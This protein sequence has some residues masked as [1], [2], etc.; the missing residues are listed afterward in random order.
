MSFSLNDQQHAAVTHMGTPLLV[1][2]GA[3][4]GKTRVITQKIA[5]LIEKQGIS[6][7][8]IFAVT[9]TNK[10]AREMKERVSAQLVGGSAKGLTIS[11]FHSLGLHI[12][13]QEAAALGLKKGFSIFDPNDAQLVVKDLMRADFSKEDELIVQVRN[14]ISSW[15]NDLISVSEAQLLGMTEPVQVAASRV[16][17]AYE[18]HLKACNAVDLDDLISRPIHLF[19]TQP[20]ILDQWRSKVGFFLVDEYQDTNAAQ[21]KMVKLLVGNGT[22]L[23]AVGDDDQSIYGWRGAKPDNLV[24]LGQDFPTLKLV[25][26]EQNYRSMGRILHTANHLIQNNQRPFEKSLWSEL[27][28]GDPI[29]VIGAKTD[30][31]EAEKVVSALMH[32][33]FQKGSEYSDYAILYRGNHQARIFETKLREMHIPYYLSGGMSYFDRA[34]IKDVMG[35]L[36]LLTNPLDDNA[37]IRAINTPRR[38]IGPG[39]IEKLGEAS[40]LANCSLY[41]AITA[42]ELHQTLTPKKQGPLKAFGNWLENIKEIERSVSPLKLVNDL[43]EEIQYEQYLQDNSPT[44]EQGERRWKNV[45]D[46]VGWIKRMLEND[47]NK[48]LADVVATM[49]LMGILEKNEDDEERNVVSL[50][51]MHAAKGLEFPNVYIVG[52]EEDILPHRVSIEE[53][54][55]EEERRLFYVGITRAQRELTLSYAQKRQRFGESMECEPSRF[56]EELDQEHLNWVDKEPEDPEK[57]HAVGESYLQAMKEMLRS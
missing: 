29:Q 6:P 2:A 1:L 56:F 36:R 8:N 28:F 57:S 54:S 42:D 24:Q 55:V 46:L 31:L 23:T 35:Y 14:Q 18:R 13:R 43:L 25:K 4:S 47:P 45:Q 27:G 12:L 21:Y 32:H 17:E 33:K 19:M 41:Q 22:G 48:D 52:V 20:D 51:T 16:Y 5:W 15:K 38:G 30:E 50:M 7:Y 9:F 40:T 39:T 53:G 34:E 37:F 49:S 3:G 26:L 10:A 11:T 44:P